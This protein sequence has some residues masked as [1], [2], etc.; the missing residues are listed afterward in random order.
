MKKLVLSLFILCTLSVAAFAQERIVTGTIKASE[1]GLPIP[2]ASI[3]VKE[4]P[5]VGTTTGVDGKFTLKVPANGR[6]LQ[7]SYLGYSTQEV[8]IS[9]SAINVSL[10]LDSKT[11][12]QVVV[13]AGG[14]NIKRREQGNQSTTVKSKEL[15][16]AKAFNVASALTGKVAGLQ[17][18]A[19][20]S[21]VNP[22][23]RLVLRG[24]RSLLGNNQAL[25]VVDNVIVPSSILGNL[26]PEDVEDIQVLNG[27][28][29]AA[30]YGSDASNGA[31]I[32]TTKTG[33]RGVTQIKVGQTTSLETISYLPKLQQRFGSGTGPDD[34][35]SYTP[36]ENQQYGPAFDGSMKVIGKPL[37][38]GSIQTVPYSWNEDEGKQQFWETGVNN[39][40]DFSLSSGD[41]KGSYYLSSQYFDQTGTVPG[42]KFNRFTIRL[43]GA[44]DLMK[45]VSF[46][47]NANYV[48][49]RYDLGDSG[50]AFNNVLM[51]PGQIPLTRY[52]NWRTDPYS[53]P[54]GFYNEYYDSP[55]FTLGNSRTLTRNDYLTGNVQ[56]K[57]SPIEALSFLFRVSMS[58]RNVSSKSWSDKY[59]FSTYRL[60]ITS[61]FS[62]RPGSV[63]DAS[64]YETQLNPEFQAQYI[65]QLSK[66]FSLNAILG[67]SSR[68]NITKGVAAGS[69]AMV[70]PGLYNVSNTTGNTNG[71][72]SNS[73]VR[74]IG[75]YADA[76]LGFRSY[77]Y[78][79]LTARNDWRSVLAQENR[80]LFYPAA[81]ISFIASDAIP[82]LKES[83]VISSLK[84]RGGVS[85]VGLVNLGAYRLQPTFSQQYGFPYSGVPGFGIGNAVVSPD[86]K[87]EVTTSLEGGFDLEMFK[88]R[89]NFSATAYKSNTV[90]QTVSVQIPSATGFTGYLTNTGEVQNYGLE[91]SLR[92]VPIRTSYGLEVS[93]GANYT[94]NKNKVLSISTDQNF[95]SLGTF[96][97]ANIVAEVGQSF[98]LLKGTTYNKDPQG[99][100]IVDRIT[101]FPSATTATSSLGITEP[102]HR[103]GLDLS[104]EYKG[105]RLATVFEYRSGNVI[106]TG[107]ST[108]Y[109]FSGAGI[110]TTYFNRER[111]VVPNSSYLDPVTNTYVANTN[112][113]TRTGG[114]DFWTNGPSNTSVN[115]NYTY[116]AA[117][118]KMRELSLSYDLP[119]SVFSNIKFVKGATVSVQGRNLFLWAPKTNLYTDPEYSAFDSSSNA[120]GFT[121]LSQ[122]PPGR[123]YGFSLS[124]TL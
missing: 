52:K 11:L 32:I 65:K 68:D 96:G 115:S 1:D 15:T 35:P 74:Q 66:D 5:A 109:D 73:R 121:S 31:L 42:D 20:S 71:S 57:Y 107:G 24:N 23:V 81:D 91:T 29:A 110:R 95:I 7:V 22:S 40:T 44:K 28:G 13:T 122:T 50:T 117:F 106:Y 92:V 62:N 79:H 14:V 48:Q 16:Q 3:K 123:F 88:S 120:I 98:P 63:S 82:F 90:D 100:I 37:V 108:G 84:L 26:N 56:L 70:I 76:R 101:G 64:S 87:P 10:V 58:T 12:D 83:K 4:A 2:G 113:T 39:Q 30:L 97:T 46:A 114:V 53:T 41:D 54:D 80:S 99:R 118:W 119:K 43:N 77:L 61:N 55:Y 124:V 102:R 116:S 6:T 19:V 21:G 59:T 49:N 112:I 45:G 103:L 111:F 104:A 75:V 69:S 60:G 36:Y 94:Y 17:V 47:F 93:V 34:I 8:A 25:V 9:G 86:I 72:E 38:D 18:N 85:K 51:S 78:L 105:F 67:A 89:V 33:K 27:A